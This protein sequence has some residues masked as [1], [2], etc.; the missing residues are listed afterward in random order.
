[1]DNFTCVDRIRDKQNRIVRYVLLNTNTHKFV[2]VEPDNLK[3][4]LRN[5]KINVLNLQVTSDN[6]LLL[7]EAKFQNKV[8]KSNEKY[9]DNIHIHKH[10][11]DKVDKLMQ[12]M[13]KF[14]T[15]DGDG[16]LIK[17]L[18]LNTSG[19]TNTFILEINNEDKPILTFRYR[20]N[21]LDTTGKTYKANVIIQL[22]SIKT[23]NKEILA[24]SSEEFK[25]VIIKYNT[26]TKKLD[27]DIERLTKDFIEYIAIECLE[28]C[29]KYGIT[30]NDIKN[31]RTKLLSNLRKTGIKCTVNGL[32]V[33]S[34]VGL[35]TGCGSVPQTEVNQP[36]VSGQSVQQNYRTYE[37]DYHTLNLFRTRIITE[38]DGQK[39]TIE[40][41]IVK[42]I[43]DPLVM[44]D[45]DGNILAEA[46]DKYNIID[47]DDHSILVDGQIEVVMSGEFNLIGKSY[48]LYNKDGEQFGAFERSVIGFGATIKDMN[49]NLIAE[50]SKSII[51]DYTIK[52]YDNDYISDK[53]ALMTTAAFVSDD[54]YDSR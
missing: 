40:G 28:L 2:K 23:D 8:D 20:K 44:K 17:L 30:S 34:L 24:D 25:T 33:L 41:N 1:M 12:E 37:C 14:K 49:N 11:E 46:S 21:I 32:A 26:E 27:Y 54:I 22:L 31:E 19:D 9:E 15:S 36:V 4:A 39:V 5:K 52:V 6:R 16:R 10:L 42:L 7:K 13:L 50:Y 29:K 45:A 51:G 18:K 43:E 3:N 35:L 47:N 48:K 53:G 38:V